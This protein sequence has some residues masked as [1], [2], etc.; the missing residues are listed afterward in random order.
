MLTHNLVLM[1]A[2]Q[3]HDASRSDSV[4]IRLS[5]TQAKRLLG[6]LHRLPTSVYPDIAEDMKFFLMDELESQ[7]GSYKG[8]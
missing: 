7:L 4:V 2:Q 5:E 1:T 3:Q 6:F 8:A